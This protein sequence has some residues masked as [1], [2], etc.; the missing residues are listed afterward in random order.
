MTKPSSE[1]NP[2]TLANVRSRAKQLLKSLRNGDSGSLARL[3]VS[4]PLFRNS[5]DVQTSAL[6]LHHAQLVIA[7][8]S[9]FPSWPRLKWWFDWKEGRDVRLHPFRTDTDYFRERA[10]GLKS[11]IEVDDERAREQVRLH[12][13]RF[14][15]IDDSDTAWRSF[16]DDDAA[17]VVAG[18][19]G[20]E[21][22]DGFAA[23]LA[24]LEKDGTAAN[25]PF[26]RAY[27]AIEN[28][29]PSTLD[30]IIKANPEV[31]AVP[32]TNGNTLLGLAT[33]T[34]VTPDL[35]RSPSEPNSDLEP[36]F[37]M[38][39]ALIDA[40]ADIDAANQKGW[41]VLHQAAYS[42][43]VEAARLFID[44]GATVDLESYGDGGTPL[45]VA[46][47]WGH[48]EV[49]DYLAGLAVVP[50]NLRI[51]AGL[52]DI[53]ALGRFFDANETLLP[54]AGAKRTFHRPHSG[55][56]PWV[57]TPGNA[58]EIIDDAFSFATRNGQLEAMAFLHD[59]GA[60]LDSVPCNGSPLMWA[61]I[62][63]RP[64]AVEWLIAAGADVNAKADFARNGGQTPLHSA[65]FS[66]DPDMVRLLADAGASP[67]IRDD[68]YDSTPLGWSSFLGKSASEAIFVE[69][70]S[71]RC[72]VDDLCIAGASLDH[73]RDR[74]DAEPVQVHGATGTG[75]SLRAAAHH[76]RDDH[77]RLLLERGA[78]PTAKSMEGKTARDLAFDQGHASV[79]AILDKAMSP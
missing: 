32:G 59:R 58:Q 56:P 41:T 33:S 50:L 11:M 14:R 31:V 74:L 13:P 70:Y 24:A 67:A 3:Q 39:R 27:Q 35:S 62:S 60:G 29:E 68:T 5:A 71:D 75:S 25:D 53:D 10:S 21:T 66:D 45:T 15:A 38:V 65:A 76:G 8:E 61:A 7:R 47:W 36:R 48:S 49:S 72:N 73:V 19:H 40:G 43:N 63:R 1:N 6:K 44:A 2:L 37:A 51:A 52:G 54:D 55:F 23:H 26:R 64:E 34:L 17:L 46:L 22:W 28:C 9:G 78:D 20:F 12:H 77:V 18:Q 30:A 42:N 4:H 69:A 79:V 16:N 57:P